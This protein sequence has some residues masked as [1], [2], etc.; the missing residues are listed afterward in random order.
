MRFFSRFSLRG[1]ASC[2]IGGAMSLLLANPLPSSLAQEKPTAETLQQALHFYAGFDGGFDANLASSDARMQTA[3]ALD[4]KQASIGQLRDDVVIAQGEGK[5]GDALRFR[6]RSPKITFFDGQNMHFAEKDW[7][8]TVSFFM[9]LDPDHDLKPGYCDPIQITDKEWN[10]AAF[11]VDFDKDLPR[12]FRLGVFSN[13]LHW[14]PQNIDWEKWPVDKRPMVTVKKPPFTSSTWTHVAFTFQYLNP[15]PNHVS[16]ATLYLNGEP[17]GSLEG[18]LRF[19][20]KPE[21]VAIMLGIEYIGD[22]DELAIFRKALTPKE[23]KL[24]YQLPHPI[25]VTSPKPRS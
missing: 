9:K 21:R 8:G 22:L 6:D 15:T 23:V 7:E 12:D 24:L 3:Q 11:F 16:R 20:W 17:Q 4:R 10:N 25:T 1:V 18:N 2:F 5:F 19:D 14:N 13:L